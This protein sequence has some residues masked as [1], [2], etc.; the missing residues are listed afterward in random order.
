MAGLLEEERLAAAAAPMVDTTREVMERLRSTADAYLQP[1]MR[2]PNLTVETGA[3]V[4]QV[5]LDGERAAGVRYVRDG[6]VR[7]AGAAREV[8]VACGR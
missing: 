2:R 5:V 8:V 6:A 1:A 7:E 3:H 4:S